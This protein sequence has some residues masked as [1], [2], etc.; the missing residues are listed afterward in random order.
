MK[1]NFGSQCPD[2]LL[3]FSLCLSSGIIYT[4]G[5]RWRSWLRH[6]ATSRKAVGSI[7]YGIIVIFH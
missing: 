4:G 7:P 3:R 5:A 6:C 1:D 2:L